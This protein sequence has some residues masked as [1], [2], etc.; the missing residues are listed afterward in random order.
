LPILKLFICVEDAPDRTMTFSCKNL[1][2]NTD[3]C[4]KLKTD[5]IMGRPGCVLEGRVVVSEEIEKKLKD[6]EDKAKERKKRKRK[7]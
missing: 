1:D 6:L 5:C 2:F 7:P 3:H 4:L